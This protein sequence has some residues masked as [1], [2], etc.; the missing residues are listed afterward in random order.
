MVRK[1]RIREMATPVWILTAGARIAVALGAWGVIVAACGPLVPYRL[2]AAEHQL[3]KLVSASAT[4]ATVGSGVMGLVTFAASQGIATDIG[5]DLKIKLH[6]IRRFAKSAIVLGFLGA[7]I[8][9]GV[10]NTHSTA[11]SGDLESEQAR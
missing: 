8:W 3:W 4:F 7:T 11:P 6:R 2:A 9:M 1:T 10:D 5:E